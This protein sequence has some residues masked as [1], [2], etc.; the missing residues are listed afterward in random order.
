MTT[1][2]SGL[3]HIGRQRAAIRDDPEIVVSRRW[4]CNARGEGVM[5]TGTKFSVFGVFAIFLSAVSNV[6][7]FPYELILG[8]NYHSQETMRYCGPAVVQMIL[9]SDTVSETPLPSQDNI[10]L[11]IH[12]RNTDWDVYNGNP[13]A[14]STFQSSDPFGLAGALNLFDNPPRNYLTYLKD[15]QDAANRK[16]AYNLDTY[17]VPAAALINGGEHWINVRGFKSSAQPTATGDYDIYGF[18]IR[19]PEGFGGGL[20][21]NRYLANNAG[22]WDHYFVE[23]RDWELAG[24]PA[25]VPDTLDDKFVV[26]ADPLDVGEFA[27]SFE[28]LPRMPEL[29]AEQAVIQAGLRLQECNTLLEE[30]AFQLGAFSTNGAFQLTWFDETNSEKDWFIPYYQGMTELS[31]AMVIDSFTADI[32]QIIWGD[33]GQFGSLDALRNQ[34]M[35]EYAG[36]FP[37]GQRNVPEPEAVLLLLIALA[38]LT[39]R[40]SG[41]RRNRTYN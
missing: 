25:A 1:S 12:G 21:Q 10:A 41:L 5:A 40:C 15:T 19:D 29:T 23:V 7:G 9:D 36:E 39:S 3:D 6:A 31:G 22:G 27:T 32:Q 28:P 13:F 34:L 38:C 11:Q 2:T 17:D 30:A 8:N 4:R 16:L 33:P 14:R 26:V 20:G 37:R 24:N 35:A 18:F